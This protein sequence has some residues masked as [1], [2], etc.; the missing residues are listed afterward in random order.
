MNQSKSQQR[1]KYDATVSQIQSQVSTYSSITYFNASGLF[2]SISKTCGA[3][4][5]STIVLI[6]EFM[7][8]NCFG[9]GGIVG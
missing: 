3:G 8:A 9:T 2:I 5:E 6:L 1:Q 7:S 4:E